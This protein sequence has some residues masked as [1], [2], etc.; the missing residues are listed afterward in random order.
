MIE[1]LDVTPDAPPALILTP[2]TL[3][4][5]AV[6]GLTALVRSISVV[7]TFEVATYHDDYYDCECPYIYDDGLLLEALD[8]YYKVYVKK[9][10]YWKSIPLEYISLVDK[11]KDIMKNTNERRFKSKGN[12]II[13][14]V[15]G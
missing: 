10:K 4:W 14:L 5:S 6:T 9:C 15:Q 3:P 11:I 13:D 2:A 1:E 7:E 12:N 8:W